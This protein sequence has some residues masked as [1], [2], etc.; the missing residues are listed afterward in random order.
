MLFLVLIS[1][2]LFQ[3][4]S[5]KALKYTLMCLGVSVLIDIGWYL[6]AARTYWAPS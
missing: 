6:L 4:L 2:F 5:M 1:F 3:K